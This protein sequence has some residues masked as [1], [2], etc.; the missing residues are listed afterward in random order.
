MRHFFK[1]GDTGQVWKEA[2]GCDYT[3]DFYLKKEKLNVEYMGTHSDP[4]NGCVFE[5]FTVSSE[6]NEVIGIHGKCLQQVTFTAGS[7]QKT[8]TA[9][10]KFAK[11]QNWRLEVIFSVGC[12]GFS[13]DDRSEENACNIMGRVLLSNVYKDYNVRRKVEATSLNLHP[14]FHH[15][16]Q[17]WVSYLEDHSITQPGQQADDSERFRVI[18][19]TEVPHSVTGLFVIKTTE[20]EDKLQG[21]TQKVGIEM[22]AGGI[23][24]ALNQWVD[25]TGQTSHV[26]KFLVVKGVSDILGREKGRKVKAS[27]FGKPTAE[28]VSNDERQE[29]ATFHCVALVTRGVAKKFLL[30]K[31]FTGNFTLCML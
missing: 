7:S 24:S 13:A 16:A 5:I 20:F 28:E 14:Q 10:L 31:N 8:T 23:A 15:G 19:V 25:I 2:E 22:E 1:L 3:S 18:P 30:T 27:F 26:P 12:C 11:E 21:E 17:E 29:I 6:N 4:V 9:L